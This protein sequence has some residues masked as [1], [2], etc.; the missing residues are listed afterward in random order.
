MIWARVSYWSERDIGRHPVPECARRRSPERW[1]ARW[2]KP[3]SKSESVCVD[4]GS[5]DGSLAVVRR[6]KRAL[7]V[8]SRPVRR[9]FGSARPGIVETSG[10]WLVFLD[11]DDLL[12]SGTLRQR[13]DT[14]SPP[15]PMSSSAIGGN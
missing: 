12:L 6:F 1:K 11:A 13:L 4:D 7:R 8:I 10:E 14:A 15:V 2:R 3:G 5:S 9:G